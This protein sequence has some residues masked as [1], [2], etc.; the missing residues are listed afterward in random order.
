VLAEVR[1]RGMSEQ[2]FRGEMRRQILEGKLIERT[3]P[4]SSG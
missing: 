1:R 3:S 4:T 2:D